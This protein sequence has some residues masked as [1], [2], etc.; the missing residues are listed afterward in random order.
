VCLSSDVID[1]DQFYVTFF[2][3]II[4]ALE[5]LICLFFSVFLLSVFSSNTKGLRFECQV[6]ILSVH[7]PEIAKLLVQCR[8]TTEFA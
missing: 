2:I 6:T 1:I 3:Y 7:I 5:V 4:L 8:F